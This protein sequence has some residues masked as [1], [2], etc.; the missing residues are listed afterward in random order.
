MYVLNTSHTEFAENLKHFVRTKLGHVA[1]RRI[2]GYSNGILIFALKEHGIVITQKEDQPRVLQAP[3]A[4][5]VGV[6]DDLSARLAASPAPIPALPPMNHR[7]EPVGHAKEFNE[8][9][10]V[11]ALESVEAYTKR[12]RK[13]RAADIITAL[14]NEVYNID[15]AWLN[16]LKGIINVL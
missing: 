15:P 13:E 3:V 11:H 1:S 8:P 6:F 12:I 9:R 10:P 7:L 14:R 2:D 16:E 4:P 5:P